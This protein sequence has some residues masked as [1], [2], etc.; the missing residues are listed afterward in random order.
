MTN[1]RQNAYYVPE[2]ELVIGRYQELQMDPTVL[3]RFVEQQQR[4]ASQMMEVSFYW[5]K[6]QSLY[7]EL[8]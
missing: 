6:N 2:I 8:C 5:K 7:S 1:R 3:R 4:I